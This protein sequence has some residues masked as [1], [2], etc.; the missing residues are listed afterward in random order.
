METQP[1]AL[2]R[3]FSN[4]QKK[5]HLRLQTGLLL[6][7]LYNFGCSVLWTLFPAHVHHST[8][9]FAPLSVVE[10]S[11]LFIDGYCKVLEEKIT[12]NDNDDEFGWDGRYPPPSVNVRFSYLSCVLKSYSKIFQNRIW[13]HILL[14]LII[15]LSEK[16]KNLWFIWYVHFDKDALISL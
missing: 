4:L 11:I 3:G 6:L 14:C 1:S 12:E 2:Q 7:Y 13:N 15:R 9:I 5:N 16:T 8:A 10:G